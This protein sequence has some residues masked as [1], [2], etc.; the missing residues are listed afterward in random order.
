MALSGDGADEVVISDHG[1]SNAK[2]LRVSDVQCSREL[3]G[4]GDFSCF[5][6]I[7]DLRAAGLGDDLT[8]RW[9]RYDNADFG[10][11]SGVITGRPIDSG[12]AEIMADGAAALLRGHVLTETERLVEGGAGGLARRAV[13]EAGAIW[14]TFITIGEIDEGGEPTLLTFGGQDVLDDILGTMA[15]NGEVEWIVDA[16]RRFHAGRRLGRD[17]SA[18]IRLVEDRH[19]IEYRIAD[20]LW[21]SPG[22]EVYAFESLEESARRKLLASWGSI[23]ELDPQLSL[24]SFLPEPQRGKRKHKGR[25]RK[26][27]REDERRHRN[28]KRRHRGRG[29][30]GRHVNTPP[31]PPHWAISAV[32]VGANNPALP[33]VAA[34]P[35]PTTPLDC[36]VVDRDNV[37]Q[38]VHVGDTV[39][40][41]LG[42]GGFA[43]RF[44]LYSVAYD[45]AERQ[46]IVSGEALE[47]DYL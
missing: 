37:W 14:P 5:A 4:E 45:V 6:T 41:E 31:P 11:W 25:R 44:R 16:E 40:I 27:R 29:G 39:R 35:L 34:T 17:K 33:H 21:S 1:G 22:D 9:L 30:G 8:D 7:R 18:S 23:R 32:G 13:I 38:R 15:A 2:R 36:T 26:Q 42:T 19:V 10:G 3:N 43:G 20:D 28:S 47:D 46:M 24:T 12:V